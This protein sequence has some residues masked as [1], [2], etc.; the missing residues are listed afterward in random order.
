[1]H[2]PLD[3]CASCGALLDAPDAICPACNPPL[4]EALPG[5]AEGKSLC[6]SCN[7]RFGAVHQRAWPPGAT[8]YQ[9]QKILPQCPNCEAFL[10]DRRA[11]P[12]LSGWEGLAIFVSYQ[13]VAVFLSA[14]LKWVVFSALITFLIWRF[15]RDMRCQSAIAEEHRYL[16]LKQSA[17]QRRPNA[18]FSDTH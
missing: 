8:W 1:M 2:K 15:W 17:A 14:G 4:G 5:T 16:P 12:L 6:P 11:V 9:F 10:Q 13:F 7:T 18:A 3:C